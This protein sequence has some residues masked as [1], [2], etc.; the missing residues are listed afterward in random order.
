MRY[1]ILDSY[2][3]ENKEI[4]NSISLFEKQFT[5]PMGSQTFSIQHGKNSYY[6]K[7]FEKIGDYYKTIV[8]YENEEI[9]CTITGVVQNDIAYICDNKVSKHIKNKNKLLKN[10]FNTLNEELNLNNRFYFVNM[11]PPEKNP[12]LTL[13]E[14]KFGFKLNITTQFITEYTKKDLDLNDYV[15]TNLGVKDIIIENNILP[16][17]HLNSGNISVKDIPENSKILDIS[18]S[19]Y[20]FSYPITIASHNC[21][22]SDLIPTIWI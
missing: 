5:Y 14:R 11:S 6:P 13:V 1:V 2:T 3:N 21:N 20:R 10:I 22:I 7:F 9:I 17:Y 12:I 15:G 8:I 19:P 16:L 4:W 18:P